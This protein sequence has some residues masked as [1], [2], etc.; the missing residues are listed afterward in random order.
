MPTDTEQSAWIAA[1][2]AHALAALSV[3]ERANGSATAAAYAGGIIIGARDRLQQQ[4]G[5]RTAYNMISGIADDA[6]K[7]ALTLA[8]LEAEIAE[9]VR[10]IKK[11]VP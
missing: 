9:I 1:G 8:A 7:P 4:Y 10:G 6:L 11:D 3:I 2:R 5:C